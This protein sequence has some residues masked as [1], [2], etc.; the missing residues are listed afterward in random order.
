MVNT[1][2]DFNMIS[3]NSKSIEDKTT[4]VNYASLGYFHSAYINSL[5]VNNKCTNIVE[6]KGDIKHVLLDYGNYICIKLADFSRN[7][8][9]DILFKVNKDINDILIKELITLTNTL[10]E[11]FNIDN[12]DCFVKFNVYTVV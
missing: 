6:N 7:Q 2:N 12:P 1:I 8:K 5:N 10:I 9:I 4:I 3:L 11:G